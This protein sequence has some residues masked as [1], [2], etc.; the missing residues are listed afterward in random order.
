MHRLLAES[1]P[2][3]VDAAAAELE[4]THARFFGSQ[5]RLRFRPKLLLR[6]ARFLRTLTRLE[7]DPQANWVDVL[8]LGY[9]DQSHFIRDAHEFL[10]MAPGDFLRM[11]TADQRRIDPV[12]PRDAR[13]PSAGATP[14]GLTR[15]RGAQH[16]R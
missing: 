5:C 7:E 11:P 13:C 12:A 8:D 1:P 10:G 15:G 4:C 9:H 2:I 14:A 3:T 16:S 6:R